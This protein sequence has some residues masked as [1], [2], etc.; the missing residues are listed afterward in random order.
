MINF[1]ELGT[2]DSPAGG[3]RNRNVAVFAS[4]KKYAA[5][6]FNSACG[7]T[8][9]KEATYETTGNSMNF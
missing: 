2:F 9:P 6:F 1:C 3:L 5:H 8:E 4:L 7:E